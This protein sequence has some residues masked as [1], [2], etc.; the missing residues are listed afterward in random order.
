MT[1]LEKSGTFCDIFVALGN[2]TAACF[3]QSTERFGKAER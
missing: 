3:A 1:W 2:L